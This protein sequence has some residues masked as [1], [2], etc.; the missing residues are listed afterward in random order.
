MTK[1]QWIFPA[2]S[3]IPLSMI[4][5]SEYFFVGII[6]YIGWFIRILFLKHKETLVA[7]VIIGVMFSGG[8]LLQH[9]GNHT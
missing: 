7:T 9:Q 5:M 2:I 4:L 6:L 1:T 8:L 3:C